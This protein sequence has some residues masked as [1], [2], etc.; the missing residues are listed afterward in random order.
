MYV[1][2]YIDIYI[3]NNL[4]LW[5][6]ATPCNIEVMCK[7]KLGI[8]ASCLDLLLPKIN[9]NSKPNV[10]DLWVYTIGNHIKICIE[11]VYIHIIPFVRIITCI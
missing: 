3:Y 5:F 9:R 1:D 11:Y 6:T 7:I 8:Q 2:I 4:K 10:K